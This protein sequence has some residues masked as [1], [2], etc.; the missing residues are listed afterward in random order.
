M[1]HFTLLIN[2]L[3]LEDLLELTSYRLIL[4][5]GK[6]LFLDLFLEIPWS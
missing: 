4:L 6:F 2:H 5:Y 1:E 3:E